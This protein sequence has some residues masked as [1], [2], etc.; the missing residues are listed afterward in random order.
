MRS[1]RVCIIVQD[2]G[3]DAL[4]GSQQGEYQPGGEDEGQGPAHTSPA[5][6]LLR[7]RIIIL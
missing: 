7:N 3:G 5:R 6:T 1:E 4:P 2:N